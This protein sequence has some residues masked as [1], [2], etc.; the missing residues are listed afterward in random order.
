MDMR[1]YPA[2]FRENFHLSPADFDKLLHL[3]GPFITAKYRARGDA[4]S[5]A[6]KLAMT[7]E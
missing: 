6:E 7:L 3:I 1:K 4:F 5:P 2:S